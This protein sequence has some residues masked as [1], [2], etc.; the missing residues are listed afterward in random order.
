MIS[1][2]LNSKKW[3]ESAMGLKKSRQLNSEIDTLNLF[4]LRGFL[5]EVDAWFC[6]LVLWPQSFLLTTFYTELARRAVI[7]DVKIGESL[8]DFR[9]HDA[10]YISITLDRVLFK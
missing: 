8:E 7:W 6:V 10:E 5:G 1:R 3:T 4:L 2:I 9:I